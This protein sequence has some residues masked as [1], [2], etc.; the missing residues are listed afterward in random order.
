MKNT[1][2]CASIDPAHTAASF[3]KLSSL[4]FCLR[5][6]IIIITLLHMGSV[7]RDGTVLV[8]GIITL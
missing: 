8:Q 3:V 7:C 5:F 4:N 1:V 6:I 2:Y